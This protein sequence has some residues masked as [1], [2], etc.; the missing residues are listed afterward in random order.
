M[1][2]RTF[3]TA[4][5][6]LLY[7][8]AGCISNQEDSPPEPSGGNSSSEPSEGDSSS[9]STVAIT[10]EREG[11]VEVSVQLTA[12]ENAFTV[13]EFNLGSGEQT[14]FTTV[15]PEDADAI[16]VVVELLNAQ[17]TKYEEGGLP[18]GVPEYNITI[19]SEGITV[20]WAEN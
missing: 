2:R 13:E 19:Q 12:G 10:N 9:E 4:G 16:A 15:P 6:A 7:T 20:I 1:I 14:Q 5:C 18:A 8:A 3:I 11:T 17:E